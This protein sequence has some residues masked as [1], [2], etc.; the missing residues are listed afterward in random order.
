MPSYQSLR[1]AV[2]QITQSARNFLERNQDTQIGSS[3]STANNTT[4]AIRSD[5]QQKAEAVRTRMLVYF[6]SKVSLEI[7]RGTVESAKKAIEEAFAPIR[8]TGEVQNSF[9]YKIIAPNRQVLIYSD[10]PAASAIQE[11][12]TKGGSIQNLMEWMQQKAE[13]KNLKESKQREA[14]YMIKRKIERGEQPGAASSL[15]RLHPVGERRYDYMAQVTERITGDIED[16]LNV[17]VGEANK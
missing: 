2:R 6:D 5:I 8:R 14:A 11:G 10:H 4:F 12:F 3:F 1:Q 15:K 9:Q 7:M 13:F 17:V 16:M